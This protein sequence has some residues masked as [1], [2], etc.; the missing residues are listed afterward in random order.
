MDKDANKSINSIK[1]ASEQLQKQLNKNNYSPKGKVS[2]I[3]SNLIDARGVKNAEL[4]YKNSVLNIVGHTNLLTKAFAG[5]G[6]GGFITSLLGV[7]GALTQVNSKFLQTNAAIQTNK[8]IFENMLGSKQKSDAIVGKVQEMA[9]TYGYDLNEA[10]TGARGV[11]QVMGQ[12]GEVNP[13]NIEKLMKMIMSV[14]LTDTDGR[15]LSYYAYSFKEIFQGLGKGD[16]Q[17][18]Q[19]RL[20]INL[21]LAYKQAIT[22]AVKNRDITTA[23][24]KLEEALV[25]VKLDPGKM[26][27]SLSEQGFSQNINR[28]KAYFNMSFQMIGEKAF[29]AM[30]KKLAKLN[31]F[32]SRNFAPNSTGFKMVMKL[33]DDLSN[34]FQPFLDQTTHAGTVLWKFRQEI[35]EGVISTSKNMIKSF[36]S[37]TG[38]FVS[39]FKGITQGEDVFDSGKE[40]IESF[41]EG[42]QNVS[43]NLTALNSSFKNLQPIAR[44]FGV[45]INSI[46]K[47]IN[48]LFNSNG[49]QGTIKFVEQ[50]FAKVTSFFTTT[51][52]AMNKMISVIPNLKKAL[53][54]KEDEN[55]PKGNGNSG[56]GSNQ[57]GGSDWLS[58][59]TSGLLIA[60]L[61]VPLL[62][63]LGGVL[64]KPFLATKGLMEAG[65]AA[66]TGATSLGVGTGAAIG[67][68]GIIASE[69]NVLKKH[70]LDRGVW[71]NTNKTKTTFNE[72]G[73]SGTGMF[74]GK[75]FNLTGRRK[76]NATSTEEYEKIPSSWSTTSN[77]LTGTNHVGVD[78]KW[79]NL[80]PISGTNMKIWQGQRLSP[81]T[82]S[83]KGE[84][85]RVYQPVPG[86]QSKNT[87]NYGSPTPPK[88]PNVFQKAGAFI[89]DNFLNLIV[90]VS[91]AMPLLT[92]SITM[93]TRFFSS[94][95]FGLARMFPAIL[96][97]TAM[98]AGVP[99][100]IGVATFAALGAAIWGFINWLDAKKTEADNAKNEA[101]QKEEQKKLGIMNKVFERSN[102]TPAKLTRVLGKY[103]N[104]SHLANDIMRP[105][106]AKNLTAMTELYKQFQILK[107]R[108]MS[109]AEIQQNLPPSL[110]PHAYKMIMELPE[111]IQ[112]KLQI[113]GTST[114]FDNKMMKLM[115]EAFIN[116]QAD[117]M[118]NGSVSVDFSG[119]SYNLKSSDYRTYQQQSVYGN[120]SPTITE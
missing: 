7:V 111:Q 17:S 81:V 12:L 8:I 20:E 35:L 14:Q 38:V 71:T 31:V 96:G 114:E 27:K 45:S 108:G 86:V 51:L 15:G 10:M 87:P 47:S 64:A 97:I 80:M 26:L 6:V 48:K 89:K 100:V 19:R 79:G 63:K 42:L 92:K 118:I 82:T 55:F 18:L 13:G 105:E 78:K 36:I 50:V 77:G 83:T 56:Q 16:F 113:D 2:G 110:S 43:S 67:A 102:T 24:A 28:L 41:S 119:W 115:K 29:I 90:G 37:L 84:F 32:I 117:G 74:E 75:Q 62:G 101:E 72:T 57:G 21:P 44:D 120:N 94:V 58:T 73:F 5:I 68:G 59:L 104:S 25:A 98:F 103:G 30:A 4:L 93:A 91:V 9:G 54:M 52:D 109:D 85:T 46:F 65:K 3:G 99:T 70:Q 76:P 60:S 107:A 40:K 116:A 61:G 23:L 33:G 106:N 39:F 11:T 53:G 95:G 88:T 112:G 69:A 49:I 22:K 34:F 66:R 1:R